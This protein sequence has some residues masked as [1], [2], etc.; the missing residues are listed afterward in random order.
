[1][2]IIALIMAV[3]L[4]VPVLTVTAQET[5]QI[6]EGKWFGCETKEEFNKLLDYLL[7]DD[8]EAFNNALAIGLMTG[9]C[10]IFESGETVYLED[11]SILSGLVK[12]RRPGETREYW[13]NLEALE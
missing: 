10:T 2:K 13:T 8:Y 5:Y 6:A 9:T 4:V 7:D 3:L 11:T 1:M 12:V